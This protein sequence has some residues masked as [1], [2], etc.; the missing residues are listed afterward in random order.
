[1]NGKLSI[2]GAGR[3]VSARFR[4]QQRGERFDLEL[5]GPFGQ[6]RRRLTGSPGS[7]TLLDGSGRV[8]ASG[9]TEQV[10]Q[11]Q[12]GWSFPIG[13]LRF[14]VRGRP[15]PGSP[16]TAVEKRA[17]GQFLAFD[18]SGWTLSYP[19]YEAAERLLREPLPSLIDASDS[20]F[21]LRIALSRWD[22]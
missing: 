5:W 11:S 18:Q 12:L 6:G 4:W 22:V 21:Q 3:P 16:V 17:N 20:R 7:L 1:M 9:P 14:W 15:A 10:M 2:R 8:L 13:Q 19:R